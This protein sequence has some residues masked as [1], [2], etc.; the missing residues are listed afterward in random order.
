MNRHTV[1][2][3]AAKKNLLGGHSLVL[4]ATVDE[5]RELVGRLL[6]ISGVLGDGE[7]LE[8]LVKNLDGLSVFGSHF[9]GIFGGLL[10]IRVEG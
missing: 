2:Q 4:N 7:L 3:A 6:D 5:A 1:C 9:V 8:E 10:D